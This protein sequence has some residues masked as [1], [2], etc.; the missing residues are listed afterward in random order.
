MQTLENSA[1]PAPLLNRPD[2]IRRRLVHVI[3]EPVGI[4]QLPGGAPIDDRRVLRVIIREIVGR[5]RRIHSLIQ[6]SEIF[7][8]QRICIVFRVAGNEEMAAISDNRILHKQRT[9][10]I[11]I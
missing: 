3:I 11:T 7:L 5:N 4:Q 1:F 9:C 10:V 2:I 8:R 6:V